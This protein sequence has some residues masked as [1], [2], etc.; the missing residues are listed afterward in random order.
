MFDKKRCIIIGFSN[1]KM[2]YPLVSWLIKWF[3]K[4]PFSHTYVRF[5][6]NEFQMD[7]IYHS[8][9]YNIHFMNAE[10]FEAKHQPYEEYIIQ[11][12]EPK[13]AEII[14]YSLKNAGRP[15]A[16]VE[17]VGAGIARIFGWKNNPFADGVKTQ[18]CTEIVGRILEEKLGY[19]IPGDINNLGLSQVWAMMK[20]LE[21][22]GL[23]KRVAN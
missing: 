7:T 22:K 20:E 11:V 15:Y 2:K 18:M 14:R 3:E 13:F 6:W 5:W 19:S 17:L 16:W 9:A 12:S 1:P 8:S 10:F 23:V 21:A 4:T